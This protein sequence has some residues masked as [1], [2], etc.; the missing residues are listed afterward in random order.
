MNQ[1]KQIISVEAV[2]DYKIKVDKLF[3]EFQKG[4][5]HITTF[6]EDVR[7]LLNQFQNPPPTKCTCE[8]TGETEMLV[9]CCNICGK[10]ED[11]AIG[12]MGEMEIKMPGD[13]EH[14]FI[15]TSNN[16]N[17]LTEKHLTS[18]LLECEKCNKRIEGT[19]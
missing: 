9:M 6:W 16:F 10:P 4:N 13:C 18:V 5:Y 8:R 15:I 7:N 14:R 17:N 19:R 2:Q 12:R 1:D 11:G 3:Q